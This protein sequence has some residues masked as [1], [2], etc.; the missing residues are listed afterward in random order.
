MSH[1]GL[2]ING[3]AGAEGSRGGS[4]PVFSSGRRNC[5]R[6]PLLRR[7]SG[8]N[9]QLFWGKSIKKTLKNG[10]GSKQAFSIIYHKLYI[11][12][13]APAEGRG[14]EPC[15][16]LPAGLSERRIF[17]INPRRLKTAGAGTPLRNFSGGRWDASHR[18]GPL[19]T[20]RGSVPVPYPTSH[21]LPKLPK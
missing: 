11:Q 6:C 7:S 17:P 13:Q 10:G 21:L 12:R 14:R 20:P 4:S 15:S 16:S 8:L 3:A 1:P 5:S 2:E 18:P 9:P 19:V